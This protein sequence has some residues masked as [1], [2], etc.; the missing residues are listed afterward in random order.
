MVGS[1]PNLFNPWRP[2]AML[3][4]IFLSALAAPC[5]RAQSEKTDIDRKDSVVFCSYNL[6]NWL[7][8]DRS[9]SKTGN[10]TGKPEKEKTALVAYLAAIQPDVLGVC[11]IGTDADFADLRQRLALAGMDFPYM[12]RAHGGDGTRTLAFLS[13]F[14]IVSHYSQTSLQYQLGEVTLPMQRGILDATIEVTPSFKLRCLG[15]HLKSMRQIPE[16]DQALMRRN[17]AQLL[18]EH[19][20]TILKAEPSTKLLAY[21]DFNDHPKNEPISAIRGDRSVPET[22]M[23]EV[24]LRDINGL[25]WT[26]FYDWEDS[27]SK[28][29]YFF[30]NKALHSHVSFRRSY[31]F[32]D[33]DFAKASD[34]R[35][36][37]LNISLK[38]TKAE[39]AAAK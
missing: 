5:L 23:S 24:P 19:I 9:F 25:V 12:E 26:H 13:R 10:L 4:A 31:V 11:E 37:V 29:D 34:H 7:M 8:M 2:A 14:P 38:P 30:V 27:Y 21:G 35:P 36:I 16:A 18:R 28:L 20:D 1:R 15:V 3:V 33:K 32:W 22:F 39:K 17:E 6:K